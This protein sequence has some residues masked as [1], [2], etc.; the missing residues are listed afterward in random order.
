M[1]GGLR[2]QPTVTASLIQK[3][4]Y[5]HVHLHNKPCR[6]YKKPYA[7]FPGRLL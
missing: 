4:G 5:A 2:V 7:A 1:L 6:E 3:Y